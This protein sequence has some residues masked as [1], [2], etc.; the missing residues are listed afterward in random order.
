MS[1]Y[2]ETTQEAQTE[3]IGT[4]SALATYKTKKGRDGLFDVS[5]WLATVPSFS[6]KHSRY[7]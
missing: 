7:C 4:K 1:Y 3:M 5:T 6:I 2:N